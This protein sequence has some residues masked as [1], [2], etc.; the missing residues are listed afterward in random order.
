[1]SRP[2]CL[3]CS[4]L[5][6]QEGLLNSIFVIY[7]RG[8]SN[9]KHRFQRY[10]STILVC[11]FVASWTCLPS[12]CLAINVY[13]G[14]AISVFRRHVTLF[15]IVPWVIMLPR[16]VHEESVSPSRL[17]QLSRCTLVSGNMLD[18]NLGY[19]DRDLSSFSSVPPDTCRYTTSNRSWAFPSQ[20]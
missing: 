1:M 9:R 12:R 4:S 3:R 5:Q 17:A 18:P 19:P 10:T 11:L 2:L 15:L 20:S 14:S 7:L 8:G 13:S 6:L 16:E